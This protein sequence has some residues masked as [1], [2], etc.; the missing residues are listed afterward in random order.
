MRAEHQLVVPALAEGAPG[1]E[2]IGV[3]GGLI[4]GEERERRPPSELPLFPSLS[5]ARSAAAALDEGVVIHVEH[6]LHVR[7]GVGVG[8]LLQVVRTGCERAGVE[9][10]RD[11]TGVQACRRAEKRS[12]GAEGAACRSCT[13]AMTMGERGVPSGRWYQT[14]RLTIISATRTGSSRFSSRISSSIAGV[15]ERGFQCCMSRLSCAIIGCNAAPHSSCGTPR[16]SAS[17][18]W[19]GGIVRHATLALRHALEWR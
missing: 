18:R 11:A 10:C 12:G 8:Q 19:H 4:V 16:P 15:I 14:V 3:R 13:R 17:A 6:E 5:P 9:A 7:H 2:D 1:A